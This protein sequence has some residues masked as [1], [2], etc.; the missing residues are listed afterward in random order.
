MIQSAQ[1][2]QT[3]PG[4]PTADRR[5]FSGRIYL[6]TLRRLRLL[7]FGLVILAAGSVLVEL[8]SLFS[9][10]KDPYR[11]ERVL[12]PVNFGIWLT[13]IALLGSAALVGQ[14]FFFLYKRN[15]SDF[16]HSLPCSRLCLGVSVTAAV[17]T[18]LYAALLLGILACAALLPLTGIPFSYPLLGWMLA[19]LLAVG[20][21]VAACAL[22]GVSLS[23][24]PLAGV[25]IGGLTLYL[26]R[27]ALTIYR[28]FVVYASGMMVYNDAGAFLS[29]QLHLPTALLV[30]Y[31]RPHELQR[32]LGATQSQLF[33]NGPAILYTFALALIGLAWGMRCFV[34]RK[35]ELA[36]QD[37]A[38]PISRY[39]LRAA[40]V[41][42]ALLYGLYMAYRFGINWDTMVL[43]GV[44]AAGAVLLAAY[45]VF[46]RLRT[47]SWRM[48]GFAAAC[49]LICGALSLT[50]AF[51]GMA[52]GKHTRTEQPKAADIAAVRF[53]SQ[54]GNHG[55]LYGF[56]FGYD[57]DT[58]LI[59]GVA[60]T[61]PEMR[62]LASR[63]LSDTAE[64]LNARDQ[65]DDT[66]TLPFR[67][68]TMYL[69]LAGG[70][71][72]R[73]TVRLVDT[74]SELL[75][76][77]MITTPA[78]LEALR[79]LPAGPRLL[80]Y[81]L[82]QLYPNPLPRETLDTLRADLAAL[83]DDD[84]LRLI[85]PSN[86]LPSDMTPGD[87]PMQSVRV[88]LSAWQGVEQLS[89]AIG[90]SSALPQADAL[91]YKILGEWTGDAFLTLADAYRAYTPANEDSP[92]ASFG[93]TFSYQ[94]TR[95]GRASYRYDSLYA[96]DTWERRYGGGYYEEAPDREFYEGNR[97]EEDAKM[98]DILSRAKIAAKS[99]PTVVMAYVSVP[100]IV[101]PARKI[102]DY[103][104]ANTYLEVTEQ[105]MV[106]L[107]EL[108]RRREETGQ[109]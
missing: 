81:G 26:P 14:A 86:F 8:S 22:I 75:A 52:V 43:Y 70:G 84:Y 94:V 88:N 78:L 13:A 54:P 1:S 51:G 72:L 37:L 71:T 93:F 66:V 107:Q 7:G 96:M 19:T 24:T 109:Y 64:L 82:D 85:L 76:R 2:A 69:D 63:A 34:K 98:L 67:H 77:Q 79:V 59:G 9:F 40:T 27:F 65:G 28:T 47:R 41:A 83:S 29:P 46:V 15:G 17:L 95:N 20:T 61:Q 25:L 92:T 21:L 108:V 102:Y 42:P 74:R 89:K 44:V 104:S 5:I 45:L 53:P 12:I 30:L 58:D 106:T 100:R 48:T 4:N 87:Q 3:R 10:T 39:A 55:P 33:A 101:D 49:M 60:Y 32:T 23:G 16:Y 18:W 31:A 90:I 6:D 73:R 68:I 91:C 50:V 36:G 62:E 56:I 11:A 97:Q 35:S 57:L 80:L 38:R 105:D 99:G 103:S